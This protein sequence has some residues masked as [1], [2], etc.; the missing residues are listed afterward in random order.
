MLQNDLFN[1]LDINLVQDSSVAKYNYISNNYSIILNQ[2]YTIQ[3]EG[4]YEFFKVMALDPLKAMTL[5]FKRMTG[6]LISENDQSMQIFKEH[7]FAKHFKHF[8][9]GVL[10]LNAIE[11]DDGLRI[12][13]DLFDALGES[14]SGTR[15][16]TQLVDFYYISIKSLSEHSSSLLIDDPDLIEDKTAIARVD[17]V[18][19]VILNHLDKFLHN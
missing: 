13:L 10:V 19:Q 15:S 4:D 5:L 2:L 8:A 12:L 16:M 18:G 1:R 14:N 11:S 9:I 3:S 17:Y 7:S 6:K